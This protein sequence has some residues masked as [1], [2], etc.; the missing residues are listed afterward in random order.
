[1][2]DPVAGVRAMADI[3]AE[4]LRAAS[5]LLERVLGPDQEV[6]DGALAFGSAPPTRGGGDYASARRRVG[7]ATAADRHRTGFRRRS[8]ARSR[9]PVDSDA[10]APPVRLELEDAGQGAE[11]HR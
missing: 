1:M 10:V 5:D 4:G 6:P 2:F 11:R 9:C 8:R 3:Q 7:R